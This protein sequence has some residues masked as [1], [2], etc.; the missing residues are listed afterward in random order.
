MPGPAYIINVTHTTAH[1]KSY[2]HM[3]M[4]AIDTN[5]T[6]LSN[7]LC[8]RSSLN[9]FLHIHTGE[10]TCIRY[11][12]AWDQHDCDRYIAIYIHTYTHT[13]THALI[14]YTWIH[15]GTRSCSTQSQTWLFASAKLWQMTRY[16]HTYII[17]TYL[18]AYMHISLCVSWILYAQVYIRSPTKVSGIVHVVYICAMCIPTYMSFDTHT[19]AVYIHACAVY[20]HTCA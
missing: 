2:T 18:H 1:A 15:A 3:S 7:I 5:H 20:K 9:M 17:R 4:H 13:C 8:N 16:A 6:H 14:T 12:K 11:I 19:C 10:R